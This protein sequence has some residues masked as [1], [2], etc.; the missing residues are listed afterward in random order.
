MGILD[1]LTDVLHDRQQ[2]FGHHTASDLE[3]VVSRVS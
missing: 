1:I 2:S 3:P